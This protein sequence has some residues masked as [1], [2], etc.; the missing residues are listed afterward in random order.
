MEKTVLN[1]RVLR[2]GF[3]HLQDH[4]KFAVL[5]LVLVVKHLLIGLD[6]CL[7]RLLVELFLLRIEL[8]YKI[9]QLPDHLLCLLRDDTRSIDAR[10]LL[11]VL[12]L[13][14]QQLGHLLK[15]FVFSLVHYSG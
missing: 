1:E 2:V 4:F 11:L 13:N 9:L 14:F 6:L 10:G 8:S 15:H 7:L 3:Q 5:V 12:N